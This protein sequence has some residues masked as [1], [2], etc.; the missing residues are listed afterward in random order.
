MIEWD[1]MKMKV[2]FIDD[3]DEELKKRKKR[4]ETKNGIILDQMKFSGSWRRY[5]NATTNMNLGFEKV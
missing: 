5:A 2:V 4:K 1:Q 3:K